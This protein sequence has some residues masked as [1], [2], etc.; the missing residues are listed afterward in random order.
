MSLSSAS[1]LNTTPAPAAFL[2]TRDD[3]AIYYCTYK[4]KNRTGFWTN[5]KDCPALYEPFR[6]CEDDPSRK[7]C[8]KFCKNIIG[9]DAFLKEYLKCAEKHCKNYDEI[10][11][12]E[13]EIEEWITDS[14]VEEWRPYC[15]QQEF[16]KPKGSGAGVVR[17]WKGAS[18]VALLAFGG[19]ATGLMF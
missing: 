10:E 9:K 16:I 2:S 18:V 19:V 8:E 11:D 14:Y 5:K 17:G 1:L 3:K 13:K 15:E 7:N 6:T 12:K 4:D